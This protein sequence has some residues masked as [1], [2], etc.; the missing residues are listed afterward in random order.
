AALLR[1]LEQIEQGNQQ[2][3]NDRP[4][5]E[6][7]IIRIHGATL[8]GTLRTGVCAGLFEDKHRHRASACQ[9]APGRTFQAYGPMCL[10]NGEAGGSPA[11]TS[12]RNDPAAATSRP[13]M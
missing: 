3:G 11:P 2:N 13:L 6:I 4:Q 10:R 7:A 1:R 5:R 9:A 12:R 8:Y